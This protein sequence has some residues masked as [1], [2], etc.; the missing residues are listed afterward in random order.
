MATTAK[1][2]RAKPG[3]A[4][5][6]ATS[7]ETVAQKLA[8]Y[9]AGFRYEDIP[10]ATRDRAKLLILDAVGIALASTQYDFAHRIL[11]GLCALDEG[12]RST[13]LIGLPRRFALRDA[14]VMNGVLVH[15]LDYDDT[16]IRAI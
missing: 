9:V 12:G 13:S 5:E 11:S 3:A 8:N 2:P 15:G 6:T 1:A 16:H 7:G 4:A 10:Q 14:V